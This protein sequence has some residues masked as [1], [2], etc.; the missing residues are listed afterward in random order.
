[1][2]LCVSL[3]RVQLAAQDAVGDDDDYGGSGAWNLSFPLPS[4]WAPVFEGWDA[5]PPCGSQR[6]LKEVTS[7]EGVWEVLGSEQDRPALRRT[8][9][10]LAPPLTKLPAQIMQAMHA[11]LGARDV[12]LPARYPFVRLAGGYLVSIERG[13]YGGEVVWYDDR[14]KSLS[15]VSRTPCRA[16][17]RLRNRIVAIGGGRG[18]TSFAGELQVFS[19]AADGSSPLLERKI[20]LPQ[21]GL[22]ACLAPNG[23]LLVVCETLLL[24]VRSDLSLDTLYGLAGLALHLDCPRYVATWGFWG[25]WPTVRFV[26]DDIMV[27]TVGGFVYLKRIDCPGRPRFQESWLLPKGLLPS[28]PPTR[29]YFQDPPG[30]GRRN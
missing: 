26:G 4:A 10:A 15:G 2:V 28:A 3:A 30:A 1:M 12:Q 22:T 13:E 16:F 6:L 18:L 21:P 19:D 9:D 11:Y 25:E 14:A 17:A 29:L 23:N 24:E 20:T 5:F 8:G 27:G 7:L